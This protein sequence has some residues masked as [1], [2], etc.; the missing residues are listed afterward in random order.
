MTI[1]KTSV[2]S[3]LPILGLLVL[4]T[5]AQLSRADLSNGLG[6]H[7]A[8]VDWSQALDK[9]KEDNKPLMV[10]SSVK[11][12]P[13]PSQWPMVFKSGLFETVWVYSVNRICCFDTRNA[14]TKN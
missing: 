5:I 11:N 8:W 14:P 12:Q 3:R 10:N 1:R 2:V 13:I 9:A 4:S 6:D 7:I